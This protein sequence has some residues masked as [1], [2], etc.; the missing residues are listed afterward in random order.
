MKNCLQN[1]PIR[2]AILFASFFLGVF[3]TAQVFAS[4]TYESSQVVQADAVLPAS[5]FKS[6]LYKIDPQ[7]QND[8]IMNTYRVTSRY[9]NFEVTS[10]VAL[11]KLIVEIEALQCHRMDAVGFKRHPVVIT[12]DAGR[13]SDQ[14]FAVRFTRDVTRRNTDPEHFCE[15]ITM[16]LSRGDMERTPANSH[17]LTDGRRPIDHCAAVDRAGQRAVVF[18][19]L[20]PT[21]ARLAHGPHR[22][23]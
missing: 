6:N 9:G 17:P 23:Q 7:V 3:F 13:F 21:L 10:T 1:N 5:F 15:R 14:V 4:D 18:L 12:A 8:G 11:Y 20:Q 2:L 19:F 22:L 16:H